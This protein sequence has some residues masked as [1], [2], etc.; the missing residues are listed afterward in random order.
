MDWDIFLALAKAT[1][2]AMKS[3]AISSATMAGMSAFY[4]AKR[5]DEEEEKTK[6]LQAQ[7]SAKTASLR[8]KEAQEREQ[9]KVQNY[10][11]GQWL[12]KQQEKATAP[13]LGANLRTER[14]EELLEE[15][16]KSLSAEPQEWQTAYN[17]YQAEKEADLQAGLMAYYEGRKAGEAEVQEKSW[18]QKGLD[19]IDGHQPLTA[20]AVGVGVG[21]AVAAII[22]TGGLAIPAAIAVLALGVGVAG[23][24]VA[25][26]TVGLNAYYDRPP[27]TN[28]LTNTG[29]AAGATLLT[30]A[31]VIGAGL[32][33]NAIAVPVTKAVGAV[34]TAQPAVCAVAAPVFKA[35]DYGWTSY[36]AWQANRTLE[37]P[38]ADTPEKLAAGVTIALAGLELLE[39]DELLPI[40][41]P[42]DDIARRAITEKFR[43]E[44]AEN[45]LEGGVKFLKEEL[46][47][48]ETANVIRS[49][50]DNGL[51]NEIHPYLDWKKPLTGALKDADLEVHHLIEVRVAKRLGFDTDQIPSV[52]LDKDV[53]KGFTDA[54]LA[55]I[56]RINSA[57]SPRTNT[58]TLDD[59]WEAAQRVY[60]NDPE[61]LAA[62]KEALGR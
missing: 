38:N 44:V 6:A 25:L 2:K 18:W 42:L 13:G 5:K 45:G 34:C 3:S 27:G 36:D 32:A 7:A 33:L 55:E 9:A 60:K 14:K 52:V 30:S 22:L 1:Q 57:K 11:F 50:Y 43:R 21:V 17:A 26:G 53:H 24:T 15:E 20:V 16:M 29:Y 8:A 35:V 31:V 51:L 12:Q 4:L 58:A 37:N 28:V 10:L 23:G 19:W 49:L 59:V 48:K 61:Y 62:V 41:L 40:N 47:S 54:W 56:A 46:G 39:P